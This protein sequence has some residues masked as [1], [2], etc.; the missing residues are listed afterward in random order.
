MAC[1]IYVVLYPNK[2]F[3]T[4]QGHNA[5]H[6]FPILGKNKDYSALAYGYMAAYL[7]GKAEF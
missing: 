5:Q 6:L 4:Y 2:T 7:A 3:D 1:T